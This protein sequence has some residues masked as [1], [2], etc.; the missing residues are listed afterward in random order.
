MRARFATVV[1]AIAC[2]P[3]QA[4]RADISCIECHRDQ[5]ISQLRTPAI[6]VSE[7]THGRNDV[8]CTGCHGGRPD[9]RTVRAHD[10][11]ADFRPR[12]IPQAVPPICGRCH[13]DAE[14]MAESGL[15]TDQLG[16]YEQSAHGLALAAGNWRAP[17]CISCHTAHSVRS[18]SDPEAPVHPNHV[19]DV[20]SDCHSSEVVMGGM[21][22]PTDQE[23]QWRRSV[24]GRVWESRV[25]EGAYDNPDPDRILPPTCAGCH[26]GHGAQEGS[27]AVAR[28][29]VCHQAVREA[30]D[31]GPHREAFQRRGFLDCVECHGSHDIRRA[32]SSLLGVGREAACRSCHAQ[33]QE[34][35]ERIEGMGRHLALAE[36]A[37]RRA[38]ASSSISDEQR[39]H[40]RELRAELRLRVHALD[41][42]AVE[43][44][45]EGLVA[46]SGEIQ[47]SAE[48]TTSTEAEPWWSGLVLQ[49]S[50]VAGVVLI[51]LLSVLGLWLRK[52]FAR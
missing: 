25:E 35:F 30:F 34:M 32:D 17:N 13:A 37:E 33:D 52:R 8:D 11:S 42:E 27:Q 3:V 1:F 18:A 12:P 47:P 19:V 46:A 14:R 41:H 36:A 20:C 4:A 49:T 22:L 26:D 28:C 10:S 43:R 50:V 16:L 24:H 7:S 23:R 40:L 31:S 6:E 9:E 48:A 5:R 29:G 21:D 51:I 2:L 45:S 38:E 44:L 15:P 39:E